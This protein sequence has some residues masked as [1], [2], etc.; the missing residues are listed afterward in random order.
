MD[1]HKFEKQL[2]L[3]YASNKTIE[4][5]MKQ[6]R[7]FLKFC[8]GEITQTK[9][10]D[11]IINRREKVCT[12]SCN[13]FI[14]AF[15]KYCEISN[16][17]FKTPKQK[18]SKSKEK[19]YLT[20]K[21]L[22]HNII[23][24]TS[25]LFQNYEEVD[26]LLCV[27]FYTGLRPNEIIKLKINHIDFNKNLFIVKNG[28][29]EKDRIIPFLNNKLTKKLKQYIQTNNKEYLFNITNPQMVYIFKKIEENCGLNYKLSPYIMRRSFAKHCIKIGIDVYS[30]QNMMGHT[31]ISMTLRYAKPDEK[32]LIE[33]CEKVREQNG[34]L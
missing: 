5:Y 3:T 23:Q 22:E 20:L 29:G 34:N 2:K 11:Y 19:P 4:S 33:I 30:L 14:N 28:K 6:I 31:D 16:I 1:V 32:M 10:D 8:N 7:P 26:L 21:E 9:V 15:K 17:I 24:Y 27:M 12:S 13:L 25:S 18:G